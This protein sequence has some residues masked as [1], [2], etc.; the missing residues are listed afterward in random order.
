MKVSR[1]HRTLTEEVDDLLGSLPESFVVAP[2]GQLRL[3]AGPPGVHL[4]VA[5]DDATGT[6]TPDPAALSLRLRALLAEHLTLV[7]YVHPI[8]VGPETEAVTNA[9]RVP[10]EL[11]VELLV[12]GA[13]I[14][15]DYVLNGIRRLASGG[16]LL[17]EREAPGPVRGWTGAAALH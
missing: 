10:P 4:V 17:T 7:P 3:V 6:T 15:S 13:T 1:P 5:D 16:I 8:V 9:T 2:V 11:L 12:E 14:L